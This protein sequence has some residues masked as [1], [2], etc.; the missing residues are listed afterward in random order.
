MKFYLT[1]THE[2]K[3]ITVKSWNGSGYGPDCFYDLEVNFPEDHEK[4]DGGEAYICTSE[5]YEGLKEWWG[6]EIEAMNE[7]RPGNDDM[8]YSNHPDENITIFA[9]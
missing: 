1:D 2:E 3:E 8:D 4:V 5:E 9:D 7:G 6:E